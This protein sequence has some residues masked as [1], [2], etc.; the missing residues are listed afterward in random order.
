MDHLQRVS[1]LVRRDRKHLQPRTMGEKEHKR[2][3]G[4]VGSRALRQY[5]RITAKIVQLKP[6]VLP[7]QNVR[8]AAKG[9]KLFSLRRILHR[10]PT[11]KI[12]AIP[13]VFCSLRETQIMTQAGFLIG[14]GQFLNQLQYNG[15]LI[16]YFEYSTGHLLIA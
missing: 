13:G 2:K 7:P 3:R 15:S 16:C 10:T 5:K 14:K 8:W 4:R 9:L 1:L 12:N 6:R 11:T